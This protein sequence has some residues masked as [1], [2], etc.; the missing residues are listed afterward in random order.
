MSVEDFLV[1][2]GTEELPPKALR[3]L[4]L[5]FSENIEQ[6]LIDANLHFKSVKAFSTP[7]RLAVYVESLEICQADK[8]VERRGP[9]ISAAYDKNGNPT[10]AALGF[11]KSCGVE[12]SNLLKLETDK[13]EWL[14]YKFSQKGQKASQLIPDFVITALDQ[15]PIPKRMRWGSLK[16]EFVRPVHWVVLLLGCNIIP[17]KI[18]GIE[19]NCKTRGHR[20]HENHEIDLNDASEYAQVLK[21]KGRVIVDFDERLNLVENQVKE[22]AKKI[23][24][25]AVID[26]ELLEEVTSMVEWPSA[27]AGDFESKFLDVPSEALISAMKHHQKYFHLVDKRNQ[28]LP[29]FITVS[30]IESTNPESIKAGNEKVIRPR[31]ADSMFFWEQDKKAPLQS[32]LASLQKVVFQKKLGTLLDKTNRTK[33]LAAAIA[34]G[35]GENISYAERAAELCKCDLMTEM[36]GEFPDLQGTMGRYYARNDN[37]PE[38][39]SAALEQYYWPRFSGDKIPETVISQCLALADKIDTIVGIFGI[40]LVPTGDKDPFALRRSVLGCIRILIEA[41]I[42]V[43]LLKLLDTSFSCYLKQTAKLLDPD[44]VKNVYEFMMARLPVYYKSQGI[45]SDSVES[46][47]CL[48][49]SILND[50]DKKI[51]A[52]NKFR[53]LPQAESLAEANKRISNIIKKAV[54][55]KPEKVNKKLLSE[56]SEIDLAEQIEVSSKQLKPLFEQ[57]NYEEAMNTLAKLRETVDRFFDNVMVMDDNIK[58]RNNRLSLLAALR[59][60]FLTIADISKLQS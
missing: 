35:L 14:A 50:S 19:S 28:L 12:I 53:K 1:E 25:I 49:P 7:R 42:T 3:K 15:L 10:K 51:R 36:V 58:V 56:S 13:G 11:A 30:N 40:G 52:V 22:V 43:D 20:F 2:I 59:S 9:A 21:K 31:L 8:T 44:T 38:Q 6:Q 57:R 48:R 27:I 37:E 16:V 29:G 26:P 4:S 32:K 18:Y 23:G 41:N 45:D 24:G 54:D 5:A 39:V 47:I 60:Q 17:A 55:F 34:K 33:V 46:V